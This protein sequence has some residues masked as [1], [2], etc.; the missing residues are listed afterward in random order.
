VLEDRVRVTREAACDA[1]GIDEAA[2]ED[3]VRRRLGLHGDGVADAVALHDGRGA[4]VS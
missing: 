3:A 1:L 2:L 4:A